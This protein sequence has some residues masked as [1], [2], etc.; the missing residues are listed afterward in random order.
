MD[1]INQKIASLREQVKA[2]QQEFNM[3]IRFHETWKPAA[4]DED[5]RK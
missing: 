1:A 5:L 4:Y 3:A 2:A